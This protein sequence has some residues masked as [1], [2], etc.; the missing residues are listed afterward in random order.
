MARSDL[1]VEEKSLGYATAI[2]FHKDN[3]KARLGIRI[4][5]ALGLSFFANANIDRPAQSFGILKKYIDTQLLF[6]VIC[7]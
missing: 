3:G 1:A 7:F 6:L 2:G 4:L 5:P